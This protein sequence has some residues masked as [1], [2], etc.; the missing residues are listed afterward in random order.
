MRSSSLNNS[1]FPL[2]INVFIF[3]MMLTNLSN[4]FGT[5]RSVTNTKSYVE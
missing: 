5:V 4:S 1:I 3:K 2:C